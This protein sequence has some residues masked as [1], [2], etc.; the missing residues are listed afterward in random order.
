MRFPN[1]INLTHDICFDQT[2]FEHYW[3]TDIVQIHSLSTNVARMHPYQHKS[4]TLTHD[5]FLKIHTIHVL[6]RV[7]DTSAT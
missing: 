5:K 7:S 6:I 2:G 4:D 1:N 3:H